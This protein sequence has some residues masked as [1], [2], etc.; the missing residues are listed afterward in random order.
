[1]I[2]ISV[3]EI[4]GALGARRAQFRRRAHDFRHCAPDVCT[5]FQPFII[6]ILM[7]HY[8][9]HIH[10]YV[11]VYIHMHVLSLKYVPYLENHYS[12]VMV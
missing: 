2:Y 4:N 10:L 1:M 6:L 8:R 9:L 12:I 7:S 3:F 5:F 11:C